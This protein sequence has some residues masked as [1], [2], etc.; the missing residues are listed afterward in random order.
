MPIAEDV[1]DI[2]GIDLITRLPVSHDGFN[3]IL[4]C[5]DNLSK[6][7]IAVPLKDQLAETIIHAFFNNVIAKHGCPKIVI[8][9]RGAN[10]SGERSRDFFRYFA[11]KRRLTSAYHPE[12][13]GQTERFNRTLKTSLTMYVDENQKNW[14]SF[15]QAITFAYN[16]TTHDVTKVTPFEAVF[17]RKPR[18]P[19]DNLIERSEF[20]DPRRPAPGTL[21]S[22]DVLKM[23][24]LMKINQLR[25]KKRLDAKLC[26]PTFSEGDL[27]LV[28]RPTYAKDIASKLTF[29]YVGPYR[30]AKKL[31][32][33]SY[34]VANVKGHSG[35]SVI[36]AWHLRPF[37]ARD[38]DVANYPAYHNYVPLPVDAPSTPANQN[39][40]I[41]PIDLIVP[42][43]PDDESIVVDEDVESTLYAPPCDVAA[44]EAVDVHSNPL[45]PGTC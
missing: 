20:I 19:L 45:K 43:E 1:F 3:T 33:I 21:S 25:N 9:D 37:I 41:P 35:T 12:S 6:Y 29:T 13:N 10:I 30:I 42:E 8:S 39:D 18:I 38:G 27:V 22:E 7:A 36:H 26:Q 40:E 24:D 34:A 2:V 11:I 28:K 31:S 32:D 5:T 17:G 4:V 14:P 16:I 23:K 44:Y 15:I